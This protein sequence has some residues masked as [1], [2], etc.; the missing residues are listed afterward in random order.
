M[1]STIFGQE[2]TADEA[3]GSIDLRGKRILVTGTSA[4]M[5]IETARAL[6]ARGA[7][8]IGAVRNM[9]KAQDAAGVIHSAAAGGGGAY[10]L[11]ELNLASLSS[12]RQ[13]A[14]SLSATGE[15]LDLI[16]TNAAV[17]T[18]ERRLTEDGFERQFATN[19][20][21]HFLLVNRLA[22]ILRHGARV[23][24]LSSS[25]HRFADVELADINFDRTPYDPQIAYSRSKTASILFA[26]E[27]DRR[28]RGRGIRAMAVHPGGAP[29]ELSRELASSD[30]ADVMSAINALNEK[31]GQPPFFIK[32][33]QQ[34]AATTVW[35]GIT[36][37]ADQVGGRYCE[38]CHIAEINEG[39][40]FFGVRGYAV[41]PTRARQLWAK[42]EELVGE[43]F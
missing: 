14:D 15:L 16:I 23:V 42:S 36:V 2:T 33:V 34:V 35:A 41:A 26:V 19:Y 39:D 18:K 27:F 11:V 29:T 4:G 6:V 13:C 5:G 12:V 25:G 24:C 20:L 37:D 22:S 1:I 17:L 40:G 21:G 38:D 8:V 28:H 43:Q 3:L 10:H 9:V 31:A 7:T 30:M 32:T